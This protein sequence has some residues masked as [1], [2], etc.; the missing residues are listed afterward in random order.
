MSEREDSAPT[1]P[2]PVI[3]GYDGNEPGRDAVALGASLAGALGAPLLIASV[4]PSDVVVTSIPI[5][6]HRARAT[7]LAEAALDQ[8]PGA[9]V[10]EPRSVAGRSAAHGL[11]D[12]AAAEDAAAVVVGSGHRGVLGRV[13]AGNVAGQLLAGSPCPVAVAPRGYAGRDPQPISSIGVGFDD[14]PE[15]WTALQRAAALALAA[16]AGIRVIRAL[17]PIPAPPGDTDEVERIVSERRKQAE[18]LTGRAT[19]S[20]SR[21]VR[22]VSTTAVGDPVRVLEEQARG[23]LD[24]LV[25]GSRGF[26]PVRRVLLGSVSSALVHIAPC[27]VM[28]V[29]RSVPFDP[30]AG[31]MSAHDQTGEMVGG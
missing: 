12:L 1:R 8:V 13:F 25:L 23:D 27:P 17:E 4:F 11:H 2:R 22:P 30:R 15:A 10:A 31:G 6:E 21:D 29:P 5:A 24:L 14:G 7:E 20:L 18:I 19:A 3:A 26:G 28:V 16:G 9:T